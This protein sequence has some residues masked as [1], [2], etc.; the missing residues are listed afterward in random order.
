GGGAGSPS[1]VEPVAAGGA[2]RILGALGVQTRGRSRPVGSANPETRP[3]ASA[4]GSDV[5][6]KAV[7][8]VPIETTTSPGR[9]PRPSAA[10][11]LSPVPG[12]SAAPHAVSP[13]RPPGPATRG[14]P[15]SRPSAAPSSSGR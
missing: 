2:D 5:T 1:S 11:M 7:P 10:P 9:S 4:L 3:D 12:P 13:T 8:E 15:A 14:T 6:A